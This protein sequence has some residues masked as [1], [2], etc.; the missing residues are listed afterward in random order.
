MH[1]LCTVLPRLSPAKIQQKVNVKTNVYALEI[2]DRIV[3]RYDV[4]IEACPGRPHT[5]SA[6]KIDLCHGKQE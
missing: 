4:R 3:Y 5:A 1:S 6:T 2:T